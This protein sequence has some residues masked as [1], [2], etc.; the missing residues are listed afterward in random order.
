MSLFILPD[1]P[2]M[3]VQI[4]EGDTRPIRV[5]LTSTAESAPC[6]QCGTRSAHIHNHYVRELQEIPVGEAPITLVVQVHRFC[7]DEPTCAQT[8]FCE[9]VAWAPPYQRRTAACTQRILS[10]AWEM[11]AAATQRVAEVQGIHVS[12]P[13]INRWLLRAADAHGR[14][15]GNHAGSLPEFEPQEPPLTS[16]GIDDWAWKKGQRYGTL[17]VDLQTHQ[18]VAV[19]ADRSAETVAD[20]LR[21]HPT[22]EIISRDRGG[23]YARGAREGAPQAQQ[24]A[25]RFHL[26][27]NWGDHVAALVGP[28]ERPETPSDSERTITP[29]EETAQTSAELPVSPRKQARWEAVHRL[30]DQGASITAIAEQVHC[31]RATVRK[32]LAADRPRPPAGRARPR[33]TRDDPLLRELW[34]GE[35]TTAQA[36]WEAARQKGYT[37]SLQTVSRWLRQRR[38]PVKRGRPPMAMSD[39]DPGDALTER[40]LKPW[41]GRQWAHF[42]GTGWHHLPRRATNALSRRLADDPLYRKAWTLTRHFQTLVAHRC[43]EATL[44]AWCRAAEASGIADFVAFAR[45]LREDWAAVAAGVTLKWSQ[46]PVE[47]LNNRTKL[48]KRMMYGRAGLPLLSARILHC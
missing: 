46:G 1:Y 35:R 6:P 9:R 25:D 32:D 40:P 45:T 11:S 37:K 43:G 12:R 47:G 29:S 10:L 42:L 39:A 3:E 36:L 44:A 24:V 14:P 2:G 5:I 22:I 28:W 7:C 15:E 4:V 21:Q 8:I 48:L 13:T 18:P 20:W 27:K 17:V 38:G 33:S 30:Y 31:D 19:L 41:S 23:T 34:D 16:V 26:L